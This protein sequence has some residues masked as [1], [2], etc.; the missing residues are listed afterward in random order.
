M[1]GSQYQITR[2]FWGG[3]Y[4]IAQGGTHLYHVDNSHLTP[5]K[6]DLTFHAGADTSSPVVGVCKYGHFSSNTEIGLGDPAHP[7][8]MK[9]E[10][11]SRQ[12]TLNIR[13]S[14][15]MAFGDRS[16]ETFI[17][18]NTRSHGSGIT[19]NL[20]LV[21]ETSQDVIAIFSASNGFTRKAGTLEI[22]AAYGNEFQFMVL[23]TAIALC[24]SRQRRQAAAAGG[25]GGGGA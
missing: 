16:P 12:G 23:I 19:G 25:G 5:G 14:F 20:K 17:W 13:Y 21:R 15:R 3:R 6:P 22:A 18:K 24:E 10:R 7:H 4:S 11:M 8:S 2:S 9:W 1:P